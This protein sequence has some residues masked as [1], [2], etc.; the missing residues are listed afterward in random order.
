VAT[1]LDDARWCAGGY[2]SR[3][4]CAGA[5]HAKSARTSTIRSPSP[6]TYRPCRCAQAL[7]A[8]RRPLHSTDR[9]AGGVP[10]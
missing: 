8:D 4:Q 7:A 2:E 6:D 3:A 5:A 10:R 1:I 9:G